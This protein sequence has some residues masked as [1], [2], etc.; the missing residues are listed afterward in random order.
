MRLY[1]ALPTAAARLFIDDGFVGRPRVMYDQHVTLAD[2]E[3]GAKPTGVAEYVEFRDMP[4]VGL[5]FSRTTEADVEPTDDGLE[6]TIDGGPVLAD[7]PGDFILSIKVPDEVAREHEVTEDPPAGWPF[8]EFWL[9][10]EVA[11]AYHH[12]LKVFDSSDGDEVRA[13]LVGR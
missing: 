9:P 4:P 3:A 10:P 8:R 12:T 11:N 6:V 1:I 5:T 13:D 7:D 2:I